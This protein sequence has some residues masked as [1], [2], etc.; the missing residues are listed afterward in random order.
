M[1][2]NSIQITPEA[3]TGR[4]RGLPRFARSV[5]PA[6]V[7]V[8]V[9]L[10]I[11]GAGFADAA[12][13]GSFLLGKANTETSTASLADSKGTPL[14]LSAPARKAPLAVNR[15]AM[16]KNLNA[17]YVGGRTAAA[18]AATGGEG[19]T[20]ANTDTPVG[21]FP[22]AVVSTGKLPA[23]T[24]YVSAT[25]LASVATGDVG[26]HLLDRP[27]SNL[28]FPINSGEARQEGMF[29]VAETAAVTVARS[30]QARRAALRFRV[31]EITLYQACPSAPAARPSAARLTGTPQVCGRLMSTPLTVHRQV[32]EL[33]RQSVDL[34]EH[35]RGDQGRR[36]R[37]APPDR[38]C[39]DLRRVP[40]LVTGRAEPLPFR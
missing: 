38:A 24:Y 1:Q 22:S 33:A 4:R 13:G 19:F 40:D 12:T 29:T 11:G 18:L 25:A 3:R 15:T 21:F 26:V 35:R 2:H 16:V 10:L 7:A 36:H 34:G 20:A 31:P 8:T 32:P 5:S 17:Q 27:G 23:G 30:W 14:T 9:S 39:R 6:A 37:P 28:D